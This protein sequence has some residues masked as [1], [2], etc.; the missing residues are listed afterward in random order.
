MAP[1]VVVHQYEAAL[2]ALGYQ[3]GFVTLSSLAA[4]GLLSSRD[5]S[6]GR[7]AML[8]RSSGRLLTILMAG[9]GRV[10]MFRSFELPPGEQPRSL[11][12]VLADV[13]SSAVYFQ[14]NFGEVLEQIYLAGFGGQTPQLQE[15]IEQELNVPA[16]PLLVPGA[17][18]EDTHFLGLY[19]MIAEQAKE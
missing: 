7:G 3:P 13:Y 17:S 10:R 5:T 8:L 6:A 19:G 14:D 16:Q 18:S 11:E 1:R 4:I 2:E 12:E 9:S 15:L